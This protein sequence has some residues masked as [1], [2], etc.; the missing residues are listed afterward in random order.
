MKFTLFS[1]VISI[2]SFLS[3]FAEAHKCNHRLKSHKRNVLGDKVTHKRRKE[4]SQ[5]TEWKPFRI[6]FDYSHLLQSEKKLLEELIIPP[7]KEF[8]ESA[9][10]VRR[11]P[12][13]IK[14]PKGMNMC[15]NVSIPEHLTKEGVDADLIILLS[16]VRGL[17]SKDS[18]KLEKNTLIKDFLN[19]DYSKIKDGDPLADPKKRT[20]DD[21]AAEADTNTNVVGWS[22]KCAQEVFTMRPIAGVMQYV[23]DLKP[24]KRAIEEAIWT[25]IHE[26]SH[27]LAFDL[28]MFT[29]FVDSDLNSKPYRD[30]IRVRSK[31]KGLSEILKERESVMND[32]IKFATW[33]NTVNVKPKRIDSVASKNKRSHRDIPIDLANLQQQYKSLNDTL[34]SE[35]IT[36]DQILQKVT[37]DLEVGD[38]YKDIELP[39]NMNF[40]TV[41]SFV[42]NFVENTIISIK[43]PAVVK[44]A[45]EHFGCNSVD[46][47]DLEMHGGL[48]SAFSHWSKR[49]LNTEY[50][51]ADSYGENYVS[52]FSLA[53][54]EDSGWYK[55]DYSKAEHITWGKNKGCNFLDKKCFTK[56]KEDGK[57]IVSTY[58]EFC[59]EF[60]SESCSNSHVFRGVCVISQYKSPLPKE[61]QY[62]GSDSLGGLDQFGDYCPY[63][64]EWMN[65]QSAFPFG[66]CRN[67]INENKDL[68]EKICENCRCYLSTLVPSKAPRKI[69]RQRAMCYETNCRLEDGK[70]ALFVK[71]LGSE[72]K[73]PV[74]GGMINLDG[75]DGQIQCPPLES[76]CDASRETEGYTTTSRMFSKFYEKLT[77]YLY[78]ILPNLL[79]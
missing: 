9:L 52:A 5:T 42:N 4:Y 32:F 60:P 29:D 37:V 2:I 28:D 19:E 8:L 30:T 43:S 66:S 73:C 21:T 38:D 36:I 20:K 75:F 3:L 23:A 7:I 41:I 63:P 34:Y 55:V 16:S 49:I 35:E 62:F 78:E 67:G 77:T 59:T 45:R 33:S 22:S 61:F 56:T 17:N 57:D 31:L 48:G 65:D 1:L 44:V 71:L 54:F 58:P 27:I 64:I 39:L 15:E 13:K 68:G 25:T 53:L 14:F 47:V 12:G 24:T 46:Q 72:V 11:F 40:T 18:P 26:F 74:K 79:K 51:I 50:M 10:S 76:I 70:L 69:D 6:H